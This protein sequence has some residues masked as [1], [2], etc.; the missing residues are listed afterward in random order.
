VLQVA[1]GWG[2]IPGIPA[3]LTACMN[4][5]VGTLVHVTK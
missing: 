5:V 1:Q 3:E 4:Q 2:Y